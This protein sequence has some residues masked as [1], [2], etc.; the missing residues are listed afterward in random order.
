MEFV[1]GAY[2][3]DPTN[4]MDEN[5]TGKLIPREANHRYYLTTWNNTA[6]IQTGHSNGN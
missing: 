2:W 3:S 5:E 6:M 4:L 1:D